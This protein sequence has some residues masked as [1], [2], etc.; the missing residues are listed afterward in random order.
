VLYDRDTRFAGDSHYTYRKLLGLAFDGIT[1]F[2]VV[3]LRLASYF[4]IFSGVVGL[5]MLI[6]SIGGYFFADAPVGWASQTTIILVLGSGQL[7]VLGIVGEY[8]GRLY[9]ESKRRPIFLIES[10]LGGDDKTPRE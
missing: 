9:I 4:G 3:P 2:S 10:V 8:L 5:A 6:Y 7:I 1:G